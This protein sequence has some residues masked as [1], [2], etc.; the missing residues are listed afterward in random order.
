MFDIVIVNWNSGEH[1]K[2]SI[3]SVIEYED[4]FVSAVFVVDNGS[5]DKSADLIFDAP[6]PFKISLIKNKE[7]LG[8]AKGC[9]I[10]ANKGL[11]DWIIFLNP[12]AKLL[13]GSLREIAKFI[14]S[15]K[16]Q[17][18]GIIGP[19]NINPAGAIARSCSRLPSKLS[20][21]SDSSGI[22]RI[23]PLNRLSQK[24][25]E[26]DHASSSYVDQVIG[27]CYVVSRDI[28]NQLGGFDERFFVY[29]EEVDFALRAKNL[30]YGTYFLSESRIF[31]YGG[32]TTE[33]AKGA[34]LYYSLSSRNKYAKKHFGSFFA[35]ILLAVTLSIE[36][37]LR[38]T[39]ALLK[40]KNEAS[41]VAAGYKR[42]LNS[43][44]LTNGI[45]KS[46]PSES[47]N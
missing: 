26:W 21:L 17:S 47:K 3:E 20:L 4:G 42:F 23:K 29:F 35:A 37:L 22:S 33:N 38:F 36:F 7:N 44:N 34:R 13:P 15:E 46:K 12:D 8:F 40:D 39:S 24:M 18:I 45:K 30:G 41:E 27:A 19:Q 32:G 28:F 14:S 31:H 43:L 6:T 2:R 9:N 1:L 10:G 16:S 5:K 11:A 25:L